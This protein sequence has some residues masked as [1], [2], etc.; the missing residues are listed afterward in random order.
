MRTTCSAVAG[1]VEQGSE[2]AIGRALVAA[3]GSHDPLPQVSGFVSHPGRG[4][5]GCVLGREVTVGSPAFVGSRTA[6][7][8][9]ELDR[10]LAEQSRAGLTSVLVAIDG[11]V[12]GS[13]AL[14]GRI[15]P[16]AAEAVDRLR[17]MGLRCTVVTGDSR[18]AAVH[19]AAALAVDDVTADASPEGKVEVLADLRRAGHRVA[20][21]GDGAND[22]PAIAHA[23]LGI[24][25]GTGT[26]VARQAADLI[27]VRDDLAAIPTAI[28]LARRTAGVIRE[29][30]VWAFAYNV[31]ALPLAAV[32]LLNPLISGACMALSSAFVV[33]NS[34]RLRRVGGEAG[35]PAV[36]E[37]VSG[38]PV[39]AGVAG[40]TTPAA[41]AR[42]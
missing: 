11:R 40:D 3:A 23:D 12:I 25:V 5:S 39:P 31:A 20:F 14:S 33:W 37:G 10:F 42:V 30:L 36:G 7:L 24:A 34:S 13:I 26:D 19:A 28:E 8:P 22:G 6:P 29:N 15:R 38:G 27:L 35:S 32:G 18:G 16:S 17:R 9:A 1:A 41:P 2:H 4:T 21:V